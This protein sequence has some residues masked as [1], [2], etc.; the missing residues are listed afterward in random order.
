MTP[1][2]ATRRSRAMRK[3]LGIKPDDLTRSMRLFI[4]R[5]MTR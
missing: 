3:A 2:A 4:N 5:P 1:G